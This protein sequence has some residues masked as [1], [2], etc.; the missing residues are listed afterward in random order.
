ME[1]VFIVILLNFIN[2]F[3]AK[4][5]KNVKMDHD[6]FNDKYLLSSKIAHKKNN[7]IT[8]RILGINQ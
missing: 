1:N 8:T 7:A 6:F 3:S 5:I 2:K 4:Y